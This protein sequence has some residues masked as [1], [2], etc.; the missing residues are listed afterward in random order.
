MSTLERARLR[1]LAI[2]VEVTAGT[3]AISGTPASGDWVDAQFEISP[4]YMMTEN[5]SWT[6]SLDSRPAIVGGG[7]F[8]MSG[9]RVPIRGS[10]TAGT[11]PEW[12]RILRAAGMVG[13]DTAAAVGVPT[14]AASGTAVTATLAAPFAATADLYYGMPITLSVNPTVTR[15]VLI[16]NY[17]AGRVARMSRTFTPALDNTT[18]AQIP[19]NNLLELSDTSADWPTLTIYAYQ[20]GQ[21]YIGTGCVVVAPRI[22]LTAG[23]AAMLEF[24]VMGILADASPAETT[25]PAGAATVSRPQPPV[26]RNGE[27][28][29]G[30]STTTRDVVR[31]AEAV[32]NLGSG[33]ILPP[34]PEN[35]N[36]FDVAHLMTRAVSAEIS[37]MA[38]S[39][40]A[41]GRVTALRAGDSSI[42]FSAIMGST[43]GNR[44]GFLL[45]PG[46]MQSVRNSQREGADVETV[47]IVPTTPGA[48]LAFSAF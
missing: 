5:P 3:D 2:K 23:G 10:G 1:A 30:L 4:D 16:T 25:L 34:N 44:L 35:A 14:A 46:T 36:G 7:R 27:C 33:A 9:I 39:T 48:G 29:L 13:T 43:A 31:A 47:T 19:I 32:F 42:M 21:L 18:L 38:N 15:T 12:F 41:P 6:G 26:W 28:Q 45:A 40:A 24:G 20:A 17:T 8:M 37:F 11:A 22:R